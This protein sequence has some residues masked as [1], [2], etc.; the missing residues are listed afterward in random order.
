LDEITSVESIDIVTKAGA[1]GVILTESARRATQG[2][3]MSEDEKKRLLE[4]ARI[5]ETQN[6]REVGR[7]ALSDLSLLEAGKSRAIDNVIGRGLPMVNGLLDT[8][9]FIE[10]VKAEAKREGEYLAA[11]LGGG[12]VIGMGGSPSVQVHESKKERKAREAALKESDAS[13]AG[14]FSD[15]MGSS[16]AGA[17]AARGRAA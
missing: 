4:A 14:I 7:A 10:A 13:R 12:R 5:V 9:K 11:L 2:D 16:L 17:H 3:D 15:I 6:A 1:G 8:A